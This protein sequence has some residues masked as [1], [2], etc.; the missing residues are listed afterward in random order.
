VATE[1]LLISTVLLLPCSHRDLR[2]CNLCTVAMLDQNPVIKH[3]FPLPHAGIATLI[4]EKI[5]ELNA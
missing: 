4:A 2:F 1:K 3:A 5:G